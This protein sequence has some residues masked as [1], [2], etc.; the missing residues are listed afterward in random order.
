MRYARD[1]SNITC[2]KCG[3]TYLGND[4]DPC[5]S[6]GGFGLVVNAKPWGGNLGDGKWIW[7]LEVHLKTGKRIQSIADLKSLADCKVWTW[8]AFAWYDGIKRIDAIC[9]D[10]GEV[11]PMDISEVTS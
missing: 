11:V 1:P 4:N 7:F 5:P 6:C 10:T 3:K 8:D 9:R 2:A